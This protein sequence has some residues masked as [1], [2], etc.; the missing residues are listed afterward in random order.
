MITKAVAIIRLAWRIGKNAKEF[1]QAYD[2][3]L[4]LINE[5]RDASADKKWSNAEIIAMKTR[6]GKLSKEVMDVLNIVLPGFKDLLA[7]I[8]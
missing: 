8:K 7:I 2:A 6:F 5:V 1:V 4:A 3:A